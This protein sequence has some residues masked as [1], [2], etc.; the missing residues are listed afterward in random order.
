MLQGTGEVEVGMMLGTETWT[1]VVGFPNYEVSTYGRVRKAEGH[2]LIAA[3]THCKGYLRVNLFLG[4]KRYHRKVHRL[5]AEAFLKN[6]FEKPQVNYID[7]NKQNNCMW[8][9]EW[10]TDEENKEHQRKMK[11]EAS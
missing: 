11:E 2:E 4:D 10:V 1:T 5:V 8:N 6:P 7:G 3:E 9:L